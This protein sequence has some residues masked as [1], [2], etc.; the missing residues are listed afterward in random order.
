MV[1]QCPWYIFDALGFLIV[2]VLTA[3][4]WI[5]K[6]HCCSIAR[7]TL[8]LMLHIACAGPRFTWP[9]AFRWMAGGAVLGAGFLIVHTRLWE[10]AC[11]PQNILAYDL[12][13][14]SIPSSKDRSDNQ[15]AA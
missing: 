6:G 1:S 12:P 4:E 8:L 5:L 10:P 14:G 9:R 2:V 13:E 7:L 15:D 3:V 11:E